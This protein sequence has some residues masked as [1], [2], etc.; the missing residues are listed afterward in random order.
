MM[1]EETYG[2]I[3]D[4]I[5]GWTSENTVSMMTW[6]MIVARMESVSSANEIINDYMEKLK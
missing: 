6:G 4:D 1:L 3:Q 5:N 2:M